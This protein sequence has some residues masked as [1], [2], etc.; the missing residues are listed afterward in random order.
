MMT[1]HD[2]MMTPP[3]DICM[4]ALPGHMMAQPGHNYGGAMLWQVLNI[5]G[6]PSWTYGHI[7]ALPGHMVALPGHNY[8]GAMWWQ[9]LN[10]HIWRHFLWSYV[11]TSW[12]YGGTTWTL[13]H[14]TR[15]RQLLNRSACLS[16]RSGG[17]KSKNNSSFMSRL[18]TR[19]KDVG[20]G[21]AGNGRS[22][23]R[24]WWTQSVESELFHPGSTFPDAVESIDPA[25]DQSEPLDVI[26]RSSGRRQGSLFRRE[27]QV[28]NDEDITGCLGRSPCYR[29]KF[30][31]DIVR[32]RRSHRT[33][34]TGPDPTN[35]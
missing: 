15:S 22:G 30:R 7:L 28:S 8:G 18:S 35:F 3:I 16:S 31:P 4:L 14:F 10:S 26:I 1:R 13:I 2:Y 33:G 5:Y 19:R 20:S 12:T 27:R 17:Q 32:H 34:C 9:V 29:R 25:S 24:G 11:G 23:R 6:G 21:G